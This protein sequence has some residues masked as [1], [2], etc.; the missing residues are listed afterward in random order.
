METLFGNTLKKARGERGM[1]QRELA[2]IL[3]IDIPMFSKIEKGERRAKREQVVTMAETLGQDRIEW[4]AIWLADKVLDAVENEYALQ[5]AAL[6]I[7]REK[8]R[9]DW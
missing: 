2:E 3:E 8:I 6:N 1:R 4:L 5:L 7:A 9:N